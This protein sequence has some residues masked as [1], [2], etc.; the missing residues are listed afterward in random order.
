VAFL[1]A[2]SS[3]AASPDATRLRKPAQRDAAIETSIALGIGKLRAEMGLPGLQPHPGL[4]RAATVHTAEMVNEGFFSHLSADGSSARGRIAGYYPRRA[5][6]RP[7]RVGEIIYWGPGSAS[8]RNAV[9]SWLASPFHRARMLDRR[10]RDVGV[11]AIVS[12]AAPGTFRGRPALVVT[13]V[14]G[15]R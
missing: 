3:V 2:S 10:F 4:A 7:W 6:S 14:L 8:G 13:V 9:E 11:S 12:P 1:A 15:A 5:R